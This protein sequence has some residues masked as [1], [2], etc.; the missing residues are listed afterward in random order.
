VASTKDTNLRDGDVILTLN[1]RS[2]PSYATI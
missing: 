1:G 2:S